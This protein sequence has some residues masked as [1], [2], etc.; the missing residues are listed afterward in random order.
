M[1]TKYVETS[2]QKQLLILIWIKEREWQ[3]ALGIVAL[4]KMAM[5]KNDWV[6]CLD[7]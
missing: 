2:F 1:T 5:V 3:S 4:D 7:T 6:N